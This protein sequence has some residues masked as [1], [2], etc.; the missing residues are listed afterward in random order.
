MVGPAE[1]EHMAW[2]PFKQWFGPGE[3]PDD[4]R[5]AAAE[6]DYPMASLAR[7]IWIELEAD[8]HRLRDTLIRENSATFHSPA[9]PITTTITTPDP[10][11]PVAGP[12]EC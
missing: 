11:R 2:S 4:F 3:E 5:D 8:Y 1:L 12:G 10:D 9:F 6:D 7:A